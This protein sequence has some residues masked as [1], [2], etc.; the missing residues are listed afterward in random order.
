MKTKLWWDPVHERAAKA[1]M[2]KDMGIKWRES[3]IRLFNKKCDKTKTREENIRSCPEGVELTEWSS[4]VDYRLDEATKV[5][6]FSQL[7]FKI[8]FF[9]IPLY[10]V[11]L[12]MNCM[13]A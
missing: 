13:L 2:M 10:A 7:T 9:S 5:T 11:L 6:L 1:Y 4:F 3:R 12:S 8:C